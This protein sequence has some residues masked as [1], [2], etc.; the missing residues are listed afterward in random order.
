MEENKNKRIVIVG[1]VA[2]GTKAAAK[3]RRQDPSADISI[4]T[5]EPYISYAGCGQPYY[6]GGEILSKENLLARTP[7]QFEN[8]TQI[9]IRAKHRAVRINPEQKNIV[10]LNLDANETKT[11]SY[12][13]LVIATGASPIV[14]PIPGVD[15]PGVFTIRT[16]ESAEAIRSKIDAH[17]MKEAIVVG[18]GYIGLEIAENLI[19]QQIDVT[20]VEK[21]SQLAPPFDEEIAGHIRNILLQKGAHILTGCALES[22]QGSREAGVTGAT[23][24]GREIPADLVILAVGVRPNVQL[25]NEAGVELGSTGAI[26][27]NSRMQTNIPDI[28]AG[29]DCVETTQLITGKPAWIPLGSTANK[30]GRVIGIN[31][32]GGNAVFPGVLGSCIFQVFNL[33]IAKTGLSEKEAKKEGFD[34]EAVIVPVDDKP[35]YMSGAQKVIVKLLA[36]RS[37]RRLI[38]AQVWGR[39]KVDKTID[40]L[41][42]CMYFKGTVDDAMQLDL[43][44]APPYSPALGAPIVAANV[45]QSKLDQLTESVLPLEVKEKAERGDKDFVFLDVRPP[46]MQSQVC[47]EKSVSIPLMALRKRFAELPKDK[48]I[49]T[50]CMVGLNAAQ[51]YRV[52]KQLGFKNVKYMEGGVTAWPDPIPRPIHK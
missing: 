13:V 25:A 10:I 6:I 24:A 1:G 26:K 4:Y 48:L 41:A 39:G 3:A 42:T 18:G 23:V 2:A 38:G 29:G 40:A 9:H 17:Q 34:Y 7:D 44:Y 37:S 30:Q 20:I 36:E 35:H 12:D 52:L 16:L 50:S 15:L 47:L 31:A 11:V 49:V 32:A 22:I 21:E 14:P 51:A 28:F 19:K 33:H 8:A 46:E 27:V 43:A 45:L 5:E